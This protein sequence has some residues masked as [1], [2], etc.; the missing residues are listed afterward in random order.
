MS[1]RFKLA[2]ILL[3][4]GLIM[5]ACGGDEEGPEGNGDAEDTSADEGME[6]M[7]ENNEDAGG[8]NDT[9]DGQSDGSGSSSSETISQEDINHDA[10][11]AVDA[12]MENYDGK[13]IQVELD[14]DEGRW[15]YKVDME[16]DSEEYE[17]RLS[18]DDLSVIN[19][20]TETDDDKDSEDQFEYGDAIPAED[21]VQTAIDE[22]GGSGEIEGW[23]LDRDDGALEYEIELMNTD[24]GDADITI[25]AES[26]EVTATDYDN[27]D[28]ND[29][30]DDDDSD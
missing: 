25:D 30:D 11:E 2:G 20:Q 10:R 3:S 6:N 7:E 5:A 1:H 24:N 28:D 27:D 21:A 4:A 17:T 8:G 12:A 9:S 18:V 19:E 16:Q 13:L 26:G 29:D 22:A 23:S 14:H 15:V